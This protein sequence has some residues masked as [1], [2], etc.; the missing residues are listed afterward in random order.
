MNKI[1]DLTQIQENWIID[2]LYS[3]FESERSIF[4]YEFKFILVEGPKNQGYIR[5]GKDGQSHN[6][7]ADDFFY[8]ELSDVVLGI[9]SH[10][11][12]I[13]G[14]ERRGGGFVRLLNFQE[15][16]IENPKQ[17]YILIFYGSSDR[18]GKF[19]KD[20]LK[21]TILINTSERLSYQVHKN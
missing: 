17:N 8:S 3:N 1:L 9:G 14:Y 7:I 20:L 12:Y 4:L 10:Q 21:Q 2:K 6:L 5:F 15:S 18:L 19:D 11:Q 13:N 16:D